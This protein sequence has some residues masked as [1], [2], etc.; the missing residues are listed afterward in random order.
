M[1]ED[2]GQIALRLLEDV[3]EEQIRIA[4]LFEAKGQ[5]IDDIDRKLDEHATE[6]NRRHEQILNAFPASDIEGHRR[7]HEAILKR[8]ELRNEIV[9]ECLKKVA[10]VGVLAGLLWLCKAILASMTKG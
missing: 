3:R 8:I 7:Y 2:V 1:P 9:M 10:Q 6:S 4:N 5:R